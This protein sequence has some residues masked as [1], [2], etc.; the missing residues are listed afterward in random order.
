MSEIGLS[1]KNPCPTPLLI[2]N[3]YFEVF[4]FP[5][6]NHTTLAVGP[7]MGLVGPASIHTGLV[8]PS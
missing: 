3:D 2:I 1:K 8:V 6:I 5:L 4:R 7:K